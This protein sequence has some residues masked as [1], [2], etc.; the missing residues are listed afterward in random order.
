MVGQDNTVTFDGTRLQLAKQPGRPTFAGLHVIVRR[1]LDRTHTVWRGAL[2]LG[3]FAAAG[4][5]PL[6]AIIERGRTGR[7]QLA[8]ASL[9]PTTAR[10]VVPPTLA[11][12]RRLGPRRPVGPGG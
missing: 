10:R 12:R 6:R 5:D 4:G 2:C 11:P 7:F 1:H 3:R 9:P 8:G